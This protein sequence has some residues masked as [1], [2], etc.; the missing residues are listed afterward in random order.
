[1]ITVQ[2]ADNGTPSLSATNSFIVTLNLLA[3]PAVSSIN[4]SCGQVSLVATGA[5]GPDY[6]VLISTNLTNWQVLFTS[7]SP[8][9]PVTLVDTNNPGAYTARFY[10]IQPGP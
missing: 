1:M 6:T 7:N 3:Q 5:V 8:P 4:V 9:T 2:V 10:R